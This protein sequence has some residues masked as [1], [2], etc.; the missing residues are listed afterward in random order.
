MHLLFF[1]IAKHL[2]NHSLPFPKRRRSSHS[3]LLIHRNNAGRSP[4]LSAMSNP[5]LT[6]FIAKFLTPVPELE[7][8]EDPPCG[9]C[10][11]PLRRPVKTP[12][13]HTFCLADILTWLDISNTCPLCRQPVYAAPRPVRS[14]SLASSLTLGRTERAIEVRHVR[15]RMITPAAPFLFLIGNRQQSTLSNSLPHSP[16]S[17]S[18]TT[19]IND[20][21][22]A[23]LPPTQQVRF[24]FHIL[25]SATHRAIL[26][27]TNPPCSAICKHEWQMIRNLLKIFFQ[28]NNVVT[29][30]AREFRGRLQRL[31]QFSPSWEHRSSESTVR[32]EEMSRFGEWKEVLIWWIVKRAARLSDVQSILSGPTTLPS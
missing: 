9:I 12:C 17:L 28:A 20:N 25:L 13:N 3:S 21:P 10:R 24:N 31:L 11:D 23:P 32:N 8:N 30:S 27:L 26:H 2:F 14:S 15:V 19:F 22:S 5:I 4:H 16:T 6:A 1:L 29:E 7:G 18:F